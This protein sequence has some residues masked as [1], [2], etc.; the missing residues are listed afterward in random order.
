MSSSMKVC[1]I[2]DSSP[3]QGARF[4]FTI[5]VKPAEPAARPVSPAGTQP[6]YPRLAPGQPRYRLLIVDSD[7]ASRQLL[8]R[9][10]EPLEMDLDEADTGQTA[11][12][13]WANRQ[14]HLVWLDLRLPDLTGQQVARQI[15][16]W[17][18][19]T[20][21]V[22]IAAADAFQTAAERD[23]ALAAGCDDFIAKPFQPGQIFALLQQHL[24]LIYLD[25]SPAPEPAAARNDQ[26]SVPPELVSRLV[27]AADQADPTAV[28]RVILAIDAH[29]SALA[30]HLMDLAHE[31]R[32][33]E[34]ISLLEA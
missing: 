23:S 27:A 17:A 6:L 10:L 22:I 25:Q 3:G 28:A 30:G 1:P 8:R 34:I 4:S 9:L 7:P 5:P 14:P 29:D 20:P 18:Q 32:Y 19:A 16:A 33:Q 2:V 15:K 24:G 11:I 13:V 21:P 12:D 26:A 31:S